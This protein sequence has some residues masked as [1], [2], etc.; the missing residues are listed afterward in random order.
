MTIVQSKPDRILSLDI[1]RGL[2]IAMMILVNNPGTWDAI[3]PPLEHAPWHGLTPT[4]L[5]FPFFL[6]IVGVSISLSLTKRK[7]RGDNQNKLLIQIARRG[8][9]I[10]LI[11][12]LLPVFPFIDLSHGGLVDFSGIRIPGVL[13]RIGVVYMVTSLIFLK[14]NLRWQVGIGAACL[15]IYWF[16]MTVVPVPGIGAANLNPGTNLVAFVDRIFFEGHMWRGTMTW[17]PEGLLS[18]IPAIATALFGVMLGHWLHAKR[19]PA[20]RAAWI[21]TAGNIALAIGWLWALAFPLNKN[22]WTSSYAVFTAGLACQF[23]GV[24]YWLVDVQGYT[25]WT[26]PFIVFGMNAITAYAGSEFL[27][28]ILYQVQ[29]HV[30]GGSVSIQEWLF[31]TLFLSVL[32]PIN[33]SLAYAVAYVLFWLG[34]MWVLYKRQIFLKV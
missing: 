11:G 7:E 24:I 31:R 5:V 6:F 30:H 18:T 20:T 4:D 9:F 13:Q 12:F 27:C 21:F 22:L 17:D 8:L 14:F 26:K 1:F 2:T 23:F 34:A 16:L 10:F 19:E 33:A 32:S 15:L 29:I 25:W 3:Y 28:R